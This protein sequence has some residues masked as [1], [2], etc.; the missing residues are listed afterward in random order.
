MSNNFVPLVLSYHS[1]S[2]LYRLDNDPHLYP[3]YEKKRTL[4]VMNSLNYPPSM[5]AT[6]DFMLLNLEIFPYHSIIIQYDIEVPTISLNQLLTRTVATQQQPH[7][8]MIKFS[9][10]VNQ[11]P[12]SQALFYRNTVTAEGQQFLQIFDSNPNI[13]RAYY[14]HLPVFYFFYHTEPS[15]FWECSPDCICHPSTDPNGFQT[16][17]A[18]QVH[19]FPNVHQRQVYVRNSNSMLYRILQNFDHQTRGQNFLHDA[20]PE[21]KENI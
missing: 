12:H 4:H 9:A 5:N 19:C 8:K 17:Q 1:Q 20:L 2:G 13:G 10:Y 6:R 14:D 3:G 11:V 18:C 21:Y 16:A 15:S 7:Y